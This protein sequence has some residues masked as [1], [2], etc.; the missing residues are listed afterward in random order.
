MLAEEA[1]LENSQLTGSFVHAMLAQGNDFKGK[2]LLL[3]ESSSNLT[4]SH[5]PSSQYHTSSSSYCNGN[6]KGFNNDG[7][8]FSSRKY[9]NCGNA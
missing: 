1:T 2:G 3:A 4:D 6:S 9:N 8:N 5:N 7:P